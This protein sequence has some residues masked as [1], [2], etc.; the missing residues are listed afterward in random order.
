[1]DPLTKINYEEKYGTIL[2]E[3]TK[4]Q[5]EILSLLKIEPHRSAQLQIFRVFGIRANSR[6]QVL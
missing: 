5:R 4:P 6:L 3:V 2:T 1:M